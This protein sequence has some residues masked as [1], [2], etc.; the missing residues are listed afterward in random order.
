MQDKLHLAKIS[1][2]AD[3]AQIECSGDWVVAKIANVS[4][5]FDYFKY[6]APATVSVNASKIRALDTAGAWA[7]A[8]LLAQ[9]KSAQKKAKLT[10]LN[11]EHQALYTLIAAEKNKLTTPPAPES[12]NWLYRLGESTVIKWNEALSFLAFLGE[13]TV[14]VI[15]VLLHPRQIQWRSFLNIIDLAGFRA[16]PIIALLLFLIGV[17]ICYQTGIQLKNYGADMYIVSLTGVAVLQE[18]GPMITAIILAG[19]T[20]AAFTSQLGSMK[21]NQEI[22]A[23]RTMGLSSMNML[24]IP[25]FF[26]LLVVLPLLT[27]WADIF[28]ILGSMLM[29]RHVLGFSYSA[30]LI[31]FPHEVRFTTYLIGMSKTP[32]FAM[33]IATVGCFQGFQVGFSADSVGLQTTRSVVQAIFLII[34]VDA[35]FSVLFGW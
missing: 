17:V 12:H 8:E 27:V 29:A 23:L 31:N 14:E 5:Q 11:P 16:L 18:F 25:R 7:L 6:V 34:I 19:R 22:D 20:G 28:G 24:V 10:G 32:V 9:L 15:H 30:Y 35:A 13:M 1:L 33:I 4:K 2:P 21:V 26:G 3:T